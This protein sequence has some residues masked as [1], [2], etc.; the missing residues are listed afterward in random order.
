[1]AKA[2]ESI[3]RDLEYARSIIKFSQEHNDPDGTDTRL[4]GVYEEG[5]SARTLSDDWNM[6]DEGHLEHGKEISGILAPLKR[7]SLGLGG[8]TSNL[9]PSRHN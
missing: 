6:V 3:Y 5:H 4:D 9:H 2:I 1:V 7:V 8:L